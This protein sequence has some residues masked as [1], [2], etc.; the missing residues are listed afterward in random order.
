MPAGGGTGGAP[1]IGFHELRQALEISTLREDLERLTQ[2]TEV[3]RAHVEDSVEQ[4]RDR[5]ALLSADEM[6]DPAA[7]A[8]LLEFAVGTLLEVREQVR[9]L[10]S[11]TGPASDDERPGW[12]VAGDPMPRRAAPT[13]IAPEP[14]AADSRQETVP[15][16]ESTPWHG[17]SP[18]MEP[19]PPRRASP[20]VTSAPRPESVPV[21][22]P[23]SRGRDNP[24]PES[25]SVDARSGFSPLSPP[26][27][28][29]SWL[30]SESPPSPTRHAPARGASPTTGG[31]DWLGPAGR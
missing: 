12:V 15:L 19:P 22:P 14:V 1:G 6:A 27:V 17:A 16:P 28:P 2:G 25:P 20:P 11:R 21:A 29:A 24:I 18:V 4:V 5:F 9:R 30:T 7:M 26:P 8:T 3:L 31:I 23:P 13:P 10:D